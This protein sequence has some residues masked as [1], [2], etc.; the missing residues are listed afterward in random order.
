MPFVDG[1]QKERSNEED[2]KEAASSHRP[3]IHNSSQ[4]PAS[5]ATLLVG[6]RYA[7]CPT[8]D[9]AWMMCRHEDNT[10]NYFRMPIDSRT[11]ERLDNRVKLVIHKAYECRT[12]KN[13][14]RNLSHCMADL[15]SPTIMHTFVSRINYVTFPDMR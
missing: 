14:I 4:Y 10:L 3:L 12:T 7:A 11:V 1:V 5:E 6:D 15:P 9:F 8:R 13:H 2:R